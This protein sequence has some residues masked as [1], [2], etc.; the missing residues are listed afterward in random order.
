[1]L[2]ASGVSGRDHIVKDRVASDANSDSSSVVI[3][4]DAMAAAKASSDPADPGANLVN[5]LTKP[6][7]SP[8]QNTWLGCRTDTR[9]EVEASELKAKELYLRSKLQHL[10][11]TTNLQD[12]ECLVAVAIRPGPKGKVSSGKG[13]TCFA[14]G[15]EKHFA[16]DGKCGGKGTGSPAANLYAN[17]GGP[18]AC[19]MD[20]GRSSNS[21]HDPMV[22]NEHA[23]YRFAGMVSITND[24]TVDRNHQVY[25]H[26]AGPLGCLLKHESMP[27]A[28]SFM[29]HE[30]PADKRLCYSTDFNKSSLGPFSTD[31]SLCQ[32]PTVATDIYGRMEGDPNYLVPMH[33]LK[34]D[35]QHPS[36]IR[37]VSL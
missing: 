19:I 2:A 12:R 13:R 16:R 14:C 20:V 26:S 32:F 3:T 28:S 27:Y 9:N 35:R 8:F 34:E 25:S 1:M 10:S 31:H 37:Q 6:I 15:Q 33:G 29:I 11:W 5:D 7:R 17:A 21:G 36:N 30:A 18:F 24:E 22:K 4:A 23:I